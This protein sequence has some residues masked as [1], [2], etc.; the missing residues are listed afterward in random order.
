MAYGYF[1]KMTRFIWWR[2]VSAVQR[3]VVTNIQT[4]PTKLSCESAPST[5]TV[6]IY[7]YYSS[8]KLSHFTKVDRLTTLKVVAGVASQK[9]GCKC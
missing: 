1:A 3:Q 8:R 4:K 5:L 6:V 2:L 9:A 7:Y